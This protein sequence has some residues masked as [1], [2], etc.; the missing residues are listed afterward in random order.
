MPVRE[1]VHAAS[2]AHLSRLAAEDINEHVLAERAGH[3][4]VAF[5]R[6]RYIKPIEE[7]RAKTA[8]A[9]SSTR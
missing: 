9:V 3:T 5:P 1:R 6:E 4:S 7:E 2:P 8:A